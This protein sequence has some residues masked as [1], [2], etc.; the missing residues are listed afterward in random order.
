LP[1]EDR[2]VALKHIKEALSRIHDNLLSTI[3]GLS[4][5]K[6]FDDK[7][8]ALRLVVGRGDVHVKIEL[9]PVLR[10]TVYVPEKREVCAL[11]EDKFGYVAAPLVSMP[12]LY[13]GKI[14]AA[15]D[16]QHPR[17]LFDV[18]LL[19]E[20]EG[21]TEQIRKAT[22]VYMI[23]HPRPVAELI[24][25][26]FKDISQIYS[27]EFVGMTSEGVSLAE[28]EKARESLVSKICQE[29]TDDEKDFL[30]SFKR[31]EPDWALLALEGVELLPAVRWKQINLNRMSLAKR[32]EAVC[33]LE[34]VLGIR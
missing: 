33:K 32:Q 16:R 19:L 21:I 30:V 13:G 29:I 17:D 28:L 8:D 1:G 22:L 15:L 6:S 25:P 12:D 11:V 20:N 31:G 26:H 3:Q 24:S 18:R 27:N 5:H 7:S 4:I 9:S 23:S 2:T 14:C 34:Q 10:G